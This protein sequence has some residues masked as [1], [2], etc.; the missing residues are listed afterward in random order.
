MLIMDL[1]N[2]LMMPNTFILIVL[3]IILIERVPWMY[4]PR[5]THAD[6]VL[7][8]RYYCTSAGYQHRKPWRLDNDR[9]LDQINGIYLLKMFSDSG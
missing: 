4:T 5:E 8:G 1:Y 9:K 7:D 2:L 6:L 3:S